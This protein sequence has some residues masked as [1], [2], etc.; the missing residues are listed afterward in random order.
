MK[1]SKN[2]NQ[3]KRMDLE[4][5]VMYMLDHPNI[6]K[7]YNHFE[8]EKYIYLIM[9]LIIG[10]DSYEKLKKCKKFSE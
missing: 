3:I 9:E 1:K 7:L 5:K 4:L 2:P 10:T 8:D 6:L